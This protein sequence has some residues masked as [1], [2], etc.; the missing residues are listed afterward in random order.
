M[1]RF[2]TKLRESGILT[3]KLPF[4][5]SPLRQVHHEMGVE[6]GNTR[7]SRS[8][9]SGKHLLQL[10]FE[11]LPSGNEGIQHEVAA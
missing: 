3:T 4:R 1:N 9:V 7:Q 11:K 2:V 6:Q 10:C 8:P 5:L